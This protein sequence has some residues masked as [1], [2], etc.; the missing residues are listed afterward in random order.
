MDTNSELDKIDTS[1]DEPISS[2]LV[3]MVLN[4]QE[5]GLILHLHTSL[6]IYLLLALKIKHGVHKTHLCQV[7]TAELDPL[8]IGQDR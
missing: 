1:T 4:L 6:H 2:G 5:W 3:V 8:K 7:T